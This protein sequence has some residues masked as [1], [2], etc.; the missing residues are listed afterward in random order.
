MKN[1]NNI[2]FKIVFSSAFII[3]A[4]LIIC[5]DWF[6]DRIDNRVIA[7]ILISFIPWI[8]KYLKSFEA[9]GVKAELLSNY[10]KEELNDEAIKIKLKNKNNK[11]VVNKNLLEDEIY[12]SIY[13]TA[14]YM[15][16][17]VLTKFEIEKYLK[18]LCNKN[19]IDSFRGNIR[20]VL[21]VLNNRGIVDSSFET[22][23][24]EILPVLNRA[25]HYDIN[26]INERDL[27]WI[28]ETSEI[29]INYLKSKIYID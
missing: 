7:L 11:D 10:K 24:N 18:I 25:A 15:E 1:K 13:A 3:L 22:L 8:V 20:S 19:D 27:N 16:K 4:F 6:R 2:C 14:D 17:L 9:F 29:I 21:K 5:F 23:V 26:D 28:M 12:N